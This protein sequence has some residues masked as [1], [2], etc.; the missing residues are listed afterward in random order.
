MFQRSTYLAN[1]KQTALLS[2]LS[3]SRI[4]KRKRG[5]GRESV[6]V[7]P[8][9]L[10]NEMS[11]VLAFVSRARTHNKRY[12]TALKSLDLRKTT[13][14]MATWE[15]TANVGRGPEDNGRISVNASLKLHCFEVTPY[16]VYWRL[17]IDRWKRNCIMARTK[18]KN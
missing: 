15:K 8:T 16:F 9:T 14:T 12:N 17:V 13:D 4:L 6:I 2:Y 7:R 18:V 3:E 1:E 11:F 5:W 10:V